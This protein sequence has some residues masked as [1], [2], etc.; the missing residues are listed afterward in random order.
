MR[1]A[2]VVVA[3]AFMRSRDG[4]APAAQQE[5]D[6]LEDRTELDRSPE[7]QDTDLLFLDAFIGDPLV[8]ALV[9]VSFLIFE[10]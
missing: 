8:R 1:R 5:E 2:V 9:Q 6:Q 3:A 7:P 10:L 4:I